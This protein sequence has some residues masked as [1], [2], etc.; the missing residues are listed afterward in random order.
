MLKVMVYSS[1]VVPSFQEEDFT[2]TKTLSE[3]KTIQETKDCF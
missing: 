3:T 1:G 2:Q